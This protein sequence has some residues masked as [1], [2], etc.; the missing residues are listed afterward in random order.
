MKN[1]FKLFTILL[2][3][4]LFSSCTKKFDE[5]N[6]NPKALTLASLD[7]SS[8]GYVVKKSIIG[9]SY[10]EP[11][12]GTMQILHSLFFD[13]YANYFATSTPNFLSDRYVMV[14]SW[15]DGDFT[16]FYADQ[17][18]QVKYSEDFARDNELDMELGMMKI[19]KVWSYHRYT[20]ALGPI[21]YSQY[22]NMQKT[23]PYDTQESIYANFFLELDTAISLLKA[24][25]GGTSST[26]SKY[27]PIYGGDIDQWQKFGS[28]LRLRLALRVK[29]VQPEVAKTQAEKAVTEGVITDNADNGWVT[30]T[31]DSQNPYNIIS[32][33]VEYRM[34]ADMESI[35]KGYADP[36]VKSYYS[37]TKIPDDTD[38]APFA[39]GD[40]PYEGMRNGQTKNDRSG[41]AFDAIASDM[42]M[43]YTI[44]GDK[45]PSWFIIR[46]AETYFL[47][48][49]GALEG[50]AMG[51]TAANLYKT[52]IETSL[53]ENGYADHQNLLGEDYVTSAGVPAT[54]GKD[55]NTFAWNV[56]AI[57]VAPVSTAPIAFLTGGTKEEQLEQ[58]ITQK[59]IG[60]WPD[61]QEAYA[62]RRRTHYPI[63][64]NRLESENLD[65]PAT[66]LPVRLTYWTSEYTN[67][68]DEV[69]NAITKLNSE[70][71]TPN[72][73]KASTK[74]WWDKK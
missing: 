72:G 27:D 4:V 52:G 45:G 17:A 63:L 53:E 23:V 70:S 50:W 39:A 59:W 22:G 19:W 1:L 51:G 25:A 28:S 41:V 66:S 74:L 24:N 35:L 8:Y 46:S 37:E 69:A 60:L 40:F 14:G 15:L 43:P 64:Y 48:A 11:Y 36:R 2:I 5:I 54:P 57:A 9:I 49:E 29:Y 62:E 71:T 6:T 7:Q 32:P 58:I 55:G 20:D 13:I 38:D 44:V 65:V 73:D 67:N 34:S 61:S 12:G 47:R 16:G 21:P 31:P 56:P 3:A 10:L 33:W 30:T 68:G 26:L 42:A 18:P